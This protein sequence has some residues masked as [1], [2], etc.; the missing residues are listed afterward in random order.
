M[1]PRKRS[2]QRNG[3][4]AG[5]YMFNSL[6]EE[7]KIYT[8]LSNLITSRFL[9][10]KTGELLNFAGD[11]LGNEW[12]LRL[13]ADSSPGSSETGK[14]GVNAR[15][16]DD[17]PAGLIRKTL[18]QRVLPMLSER[19]GKTSPPQ[20]TEM[21]TRLSN[22][23]RA[24]KLT[25]EEVE[26][27]AFQYLLHSSPPLDSHLN[28]RNE[29]GDLSEMPTFER[30]GDVVLGLRKGSISR[31]FS[32]GTLFQA[33]AIQKPTG[34]SMNLEL[35]NWCTEYLCGFSP[36]DLNHRFFTKSSDEPLKISDFEIPE[37][38]LIVL[39]SLLRSKNGHNIL[40]Y[41]KP[42]TGK[43]SFA[44]SLAKRYRRDLL[45]VKIPDLDDHEVRVQAICGTINLAPSKNAL[46]LV[47]EAD[48]IL[49][50]CE[51][52]RF[53]GKTSKSWINNMLE[54]HKKKI[55][56]ITNRIGE[57]DPSTMRR[58][59][60][61]LEFKRLNERS[62][63]RVLT[64]ELQRRGMDGCFTEEE[65]TSL[66][67]AHEVNAD[68]IVKAITTLEI[69]KKSNKEIALRKI[70]IVLRNHEKVIA[71]AEPGREK[72]RSFDAYTLRGL[73]TSF[74][75]E[76]ILSILK[77]Y[78][79][80]KERDPWGRAIAMTLLLYGMPGTG[81]SEFVYYLGHLFG[82]E[83]CLKRCSEIQS[84]WVGVTERNIAEAFRE[85]S[86]EGGIL[87]FDEADSFL[88]PR[89]DALHSWEKT[90][91]NEILTQMKSHEGI[92]IFATNEIEG[93]DHAALRRF[94]YKIEF[95][96]L[97]P[98]G[99]LHVYHS[100]LSPLA[101]QGRALSAEEVDRIKNIKDLAPGDFAVV[102]DQF[103]FVERAEITHGMLI[104][105]LRREVQHKKAGKRI[106][107]GA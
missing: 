11:V 19:L 91:T 53:K 94:R 17:L 13:L 54:S 6:F 39:D 86:A 98:E 66:S 102:K 88:Y 16:P 82:K 22:L 30:Y 68:G 12:V 87:F 85:T 70:R 50:C 23:Q 93:L 100:L 48:E 65:L 92:V 103:C 28:N 80:M 106:G 32:R 31:A 40:F 44:K 45:I 3:N 9:Y 83:V 78:L 25:E 49:N 27:L 43:T 57:I 26:I 2:I 42:G 69:S 89:K 81:K 75:L 33:Y 18:R 1:R 59:S 20:D 74:P 62:R 84:C 46:I 15:L 56:W 8:Y 41:G 34:V 72:R 64:R 10:H 96:P 63:L 79:D 14:D 5:G 76:S 24:F 97:T 51:S 105:S 90:F 99:N 73:N 61:S 104:E 71:T 55:I 58:F 67:E 38:D 101:R 21:G 36:G 4:L 107:F 52:F 60:F 35:T 95:L 77:R 37:D 7:R 47:D 29:I